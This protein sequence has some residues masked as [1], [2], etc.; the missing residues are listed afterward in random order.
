MSEA[1]KIGPLATERQKEYAL[2][3]W[4]RDGINLAGSLEKTSAAIDRTNQA[5][6]S[7]LR[8]KKKGG[9]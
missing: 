7:F 6:D 3:I 4:K 5:I 8:T 1:Q 2:F 9:G